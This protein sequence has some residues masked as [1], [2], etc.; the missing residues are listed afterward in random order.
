[1]A[2]LGERCP[3]YTSTARL[4]AVNNEMRNNG[5]NMDGIG[6]L[7]TLDIPH[8]TGNTQAVSPAQYTI[9]FLINSISGAC[10]GT[11]RS[12]CFKSESDF[13]WHCSESTIFSTSGNS[14]LRISYI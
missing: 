10:T 11:F 9:K 12:L 4:L 5:K 2:A 1:M 3:I 14:S 7:A 13:I 8:D 6:K